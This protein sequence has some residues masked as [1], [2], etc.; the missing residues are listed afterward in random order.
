MIEG[1][2]II[3]TPSC[4]TCFLITLIYSGFNNWIDESNHFITPVSKLFQCILNFTIWLKAMDHYSNHS[5]N[6]SAYFRD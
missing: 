4:A 3:E 2:Q 5:Y 1:S 6:R